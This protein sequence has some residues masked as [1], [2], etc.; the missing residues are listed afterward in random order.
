MSS[1]VSSPIDDKTY[2]SES[3]YS[4]ADLYASDLPLSFARRLIT[5]DF[6][7]RSGSTI[8]PLDIV[9]EEAPNVDSTNTESRVDRISPEP[10]YIPS[11]ARRASWSA[12][13]AASAARWANIQEGIAAQELRASKRMYR[14][15]AKGLRRSASDMEGERLPSRYNAQ[16]WWSTNFPTSSTWTWKSSTIPA[17]SSPL[18]LKIQLLPEPVSS[19]PQTKD[20]TLKDPSRLR[21]KF[22]DCLPT[23]PPGT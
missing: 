12:I 6:R 16:D 5:L 17:R 1:L 8:A 14:R 13:D 21:V 18:A 19:S 11:V 9:V 15:A 20:T 22:E 2:S 10:P 23:R 3:E 4:N 7:A